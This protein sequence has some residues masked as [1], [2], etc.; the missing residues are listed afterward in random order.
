MSG[1]I[2]ELSYGTSSGFVRAADGQRVF[3][4]RADVEGVS[5]NG[6]E[7][8]DAVVFDMVEDRFSGLRALRLRRD[9]R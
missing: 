4:H 3:F 8:G 2:V 5:F 7:D 9:R 1:R 6:L